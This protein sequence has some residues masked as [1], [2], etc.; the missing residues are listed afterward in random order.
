VHAASPKGVLYAGL[1][2]RF[3]KTP[4]YVAAVSG[5]GYLF[6]G[7]PSLAKRAF[8]RLYAGLVRVALGGR[9]TIVIVQNKDDFDTFNALNAD[10]P[11][12]VVLIPGSGVE[13]ER[14]LPIEATSAT[15]LVVLPARMLRDKGI[16]EFHEAARLLKSKGCAWRFALVGTADYDNPSAISK[17]I[18]QQ[19]VDDGSVEWWGHREDMP[20]VFAQAGIVC[21]PSYREGMPKALLE[22]A[23]AG[24]AVVTTDTVG[25]REAV[26]PGRTGDLVPVGDARALAAA[27]EKLILDADLRK[28]YGQAGRELALSRFSL[29]AVQQKTMAIYEKLLSVE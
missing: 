26:V 2:C 28:R 25:C 19:W 13:M 1:A 6:T 27:L 24:R 17:S 9:K 5:M 29:A 20:A 16:V 23:A 12:D 18:L 7:T 8:R 11:K 22:A 21:L 4:A 10:T 15:E 3:M 14:Y